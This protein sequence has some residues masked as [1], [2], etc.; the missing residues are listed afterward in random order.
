VCV[1][2]VVRASKFEPSF[3]V[4][5]YLGAHTHIVPPRRTK[6]KCV[7]IESSRHVDRQKATPILT[8]DNM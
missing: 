4:V 7:A 3:F 6:I 5:G 2:L 1:G 8:C